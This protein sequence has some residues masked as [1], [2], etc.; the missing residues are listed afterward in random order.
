MYLH[1]YQHR[2]YRI[3]TYRIT[4]V[5]WAKGWLNH[6][7]ET[8]QSFFEPE[9]PILSIG[10][11]LHH[12]SI[13]VRCASLPSPP[14]KSFSI[15]LTAGPLTQILQGVS[16]QAP[17]AWSHLFRYDPLVAIIRG[18]Q[19]FKLVFSKAQGRFCLRIRR[20]TRHPRLL[21]SLD[22]QS[23]QN[24]IE[25]SAVDIH[26]RPARGH[27]K[28]QKHERPVIVWIGVDPEF[29]YKAKKPWDLIASKLRAVR[30]ALDADNLTDV[31]CE[32]RVSEVIRAADA[33]P[34]LL[35]LLL[36]RSGFEL[37]GSRAELIAT[38]AA[39]TAVGQAIT[40]AH[41]EPSTGTLGHYLAG[42]SED[43]R[44]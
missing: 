31:K 4:Q 29:S 9:Y 21:A 11:A 20:T 16:I 27:A 24:S 8:N 28:L 39:S 44:Q 35:L 25:R 36:D 14:T 30:A 42:E 12:K 19:R 17:S 6:I 3:T 5:Y 22:A 33:G 7:L 40:P 32:M 15:K 34:R 41:C 13:C 1:L 38:Q 23:C 26:R 37:Y 2:R 43:D 18:P 10:W